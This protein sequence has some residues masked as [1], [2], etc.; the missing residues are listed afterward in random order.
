MKV[1]ELIEL[2]KKYPDDMKVYTDL[3]NSIVDVWQTT[4]YGSFVIYTMDEPF[5]VLESGEHI[6]YDRTKNV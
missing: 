1:K 6:R 2:L 4:D 5:L 3:G